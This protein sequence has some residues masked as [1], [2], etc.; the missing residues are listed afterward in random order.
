MVGACVSFLSCAS[1]TVPAPPLFFGF[2]CCA[3][4]GLLLNSHSKPKRFS[5]KLLLHLV[6]VVVHAPSSPLVMV[7]APCP[8]PYE[9]FQPKPCSSIPAPAGSMPTYLPGSAAPCVLPKLCPP[10]I[11]AT[12]SSSFMA[13]RP[14]VSRI[15]S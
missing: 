9:F 13:M 10:A 6:G 3:P 1:G 7:C 12:V 11:R 5:K 15:S 4:A 14:K 2:H 8:E